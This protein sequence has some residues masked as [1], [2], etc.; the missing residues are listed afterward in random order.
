MWKSIEK[1]Q[2][3]IPD[4]EDVAAKA[5]GRGKMENER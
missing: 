1:L 2:L 5:E 4:A 3:L